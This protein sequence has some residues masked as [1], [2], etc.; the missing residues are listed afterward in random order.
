MLRKVLR[1]HL[2]PYKK[3]LVLV[4]LFQ[5]VQA[6][7]ALLLPHLNADIIN[8]GVLP[9]DQGFIRGHGLIMLGVALVQ[10]VFSA[11]AVYFGARVAMGFGRDLRASLFHHKTT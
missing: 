4:A 8:K 10:G 2:A 5:A 11:V 6:T 3:L 9:G 7:A 1:V